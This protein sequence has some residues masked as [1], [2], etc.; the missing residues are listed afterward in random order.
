MAE[1]YPKIKLYWLDQSRSQ[2]ILWLLEELKLPYE[3]ELFYR[4]KKTFLAPPELEKIHPLGKSPIISITPEGV[5]KPIILAE[6]GFITQYLT[7]NVP[8]GQKLMPKKWR[9][10]KENT[11]GGETEEWLRYQYFLHYTEG[12]LMSMLVMAL[13][14][15]K[16]KSPDIPFFIRPISSMLANR[17]FSS[18]IFPNAHKH[19]TLLEQTLSTSS[20][21]YLCYD[22]LT[23]ADILMSFPLIA[24]KSRFDEFGEWEGGSWKKEFPKVYA[25]V[26]TMEAEPG[27]I[28]SVEK[29]KKMDGS[30]NSS[31]PASSNSN[32]P[33]RPRR[34]FLQ[35]PEPVQRPAH[36]PR[37]SAVALFQDVVSPSASN[38]PAGE[39]AT[40]P[41]LGELE[42]AGKMSELVKR[43]DLTLHQQYQL[44][45]S[46]I[47]P[48]ILDLRGQV[49]KH[50]Y[51]STNVFLG[52][53][54]ESMVRN[55]THG[56][57]V[58]L[59]QIYY[60]IG[61]WDLDIRDDLILSICRSLTM[62]E[63]SPAEAAALA[64][65]LVSLWKHVSQLK[66]I[67]EVGKELR[68][69]M[70]SAQEVL[71]DL[72]RFQGAQMRKTFI[73]PTTKALASIFLQFKPEQ[74]QQIMPGL[75]A[76]LA[77]LA[78]HKTQSEAQIEAAPLLHLVSL[79][80]GKHPPGKGFINSVFKA[81]TAVPQSTKDN[82]RVFVQ[83][84]WH[85]VTGMLFQKDAV[86][87]T[88]VQATPA[89]PELGSVLNIRMFHKQLRTAYQ[90]RN[91]GAIMSIWQNL[92]TNMEHYPELSKQIAGD[93][94]FLDYWVFVWC[95][96]RRPMMVQETIELMKKLGIQPT[97]KTYTSMMYGWKMCKD[98]AKI[99]AL[100]Q[101]LVKSRMKLDVVIWTERISGLIE[102]GR[103]EA[104]I[105][106][107]SDMVTTW[108]L[109]VK[110]GRQGE[111]VK[112][113]IEIVN[114]AFKGLIRQDAQAAHQ[115]LAW[116]GREGF[117]PNIRT[118]N[119]LL[120]ETLRN[121]SPDDVQDLLRAMKTQGIEPDAATFTLILEAVIGSMG[122]AEP[123]EQVQAIKQ[124]FADIEAAGLKP[125]METY[126][127]ML[128]AVA[129]LANGSDEAIAAVQAHMRNNGCSITPHMV[130]ILVERALNRDPPDIAGVRDLLKQHKLRN[131]DQGDQTLWERVMS[132]FAIADE[133]EP[134]MRIFNDLE[135][136][137]R[138]VTS[139]PC[140]TDLMKML[141]AEGDREGA[142]RVV[143]VVLGHKMTSKEEFKERYWKHHFWFLAKE[144]GLLS[145]TQAPHLF[146]R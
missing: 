108:K 17:V 45:K 91:P 129:S 13:I 73:D 81:R 61:R 121:G 58:E 77:V 65:E 85:Y 10:G 57:S 53:V 48:H 138:P 137:G 44:F 71:R 19:L 144:N 34:S 15:G 114:A 95:A 27:Y 96:I 84:N 120:G 39:A 101:Q 51:T 117:Q 135:R 35:R 36:T 113:S 88:G 38:Q 7:E 33:D 37:D 9:D 109:A 102:V 118:Y 75:V 143:G 141:L 76:S 60:A 50:V 2:R 29:I 66:R 125:N 14:I 90:S 59:S 133:K 111:A 8:E 100:W 123:A 139:L 145:G 116:A 40:R 52:K 136:A 54:R 134:A 25:F 47:W 103:A 82:V 74:V 86:W 87:R 132:A 26:E 124:V 4:D 42:I 78:T 1:E 12:S 55:G 128:Y 46:E 140:L 16:F 119:I 104:G 72:E 93:A 21:K 23:S 49:P 24:A 146:R 105:Q 127:K 130:T 110:E 142:K 22:K 56:N 18:F 131:V 31:Q 70:P 80:L 99:E 107:L 106:A 30:F 43:A 112:P 3:L 83:K 28:K 94:E 64:H 6:S 89:D 20:G 126:G 11:L 67:G 63:K 69:V 5:D 92:T 32:E 41:V 62:G 68:F 122:D 115:V 98:P 79:V 97:V